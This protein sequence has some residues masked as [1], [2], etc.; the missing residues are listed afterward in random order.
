MKPSIHRILVFSCAVLMLYSGFRLGK[1][2]ME[3]HKAQSRYQE[4]NA[5]LRF[6][7]PSDSQKEENENSPNRT[8]D[9]GSFLDDRFLS[10]EV[11]DIIPAVS[12][13]ALEAINP[14]IAAWILVP[15]TRLS[16]PV[17][18]GKD[19]EY[20]LNHL[21]SGEINGSGCP[22]FDFR[23][24]P[25]FTDFHMIIYGHHMKNGTMFAALENYKDQD[26][27]EKNPAFWLLTP[28]AAWKLEIFSA[29]VAD[30]QD[31]AWK[32]DFS[33]EQEREAW[34]QAVT[35]K[36]LISCRIA[37]ETEDQ[38]VTLSTCTYDFENARLVVHGILK[39]E[40]R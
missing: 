13:E 2:W 25:D 38:V 31:N 11:P 26:F 21:F 9:T 33:G 22:F 15:E 36:S 17:V 39:G 34:L 8:P 23:T 19:N 16:Y 18:Q 4:L 37:P 40:I 28:E 27:Y 14:D 20:Y 3:Y 5:C 10:S 6:D 24:S 30:E 7:S 12:F 29:Y 1:I 32:L 35:E